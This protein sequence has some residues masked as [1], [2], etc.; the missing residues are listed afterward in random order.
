MYAIHLLCCISIL[1]GLELNN[2]AGYFLLVIALTASNNIFIR[3]I[4]ITKP[5][6]LHIIFISPRLFVCVHYNLCVLV[7]PAFVCILWKRVGN[8]IQ[9]IA[10]KSVTSISFFLG[11]IWLTFRSCKLRQQRDK[12]L[13]SQL[14]WFLIHCTEIIVH[15][16]REQTCTTKAFPKL[17]YLILDKHTSLLRNPWP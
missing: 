2:L 9:V 6:M 7:L 10:K 4:N 13:R 14:V 16:W 8:E 12:L 11:T 17:K 1:P 15:T 5:I 3:T